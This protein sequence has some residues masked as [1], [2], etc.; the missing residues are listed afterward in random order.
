MSISITV[1]I[2]FFAILICASPGILT[3]E[4]GNLGVSRYGNPGHSIHSNSGQSSTK[5]LSGP[6]LNQG[7]KRKI[8]LSWS[9]T[10]LRDSLRNLSRQQKIAVFLDRR[11]D[12][13][14]LI[15]LQTDLLPIEEIFFIIAD[16]ADIAVCR[17]GNLFYFGPRAEV[18]GLRWIRQSH[19]ENAKKLPASSRRILFSPGS[20]SWTQL[21]QPH[22]VLINLTD[23]SEI[24][25][26]DVNV[27]HDLWPAYDLPPLILLD[28]LL[29]LT[30]GFNQYLKLSAEDDRIRVEST[31]QSSPPQRVRDQFK[32]DLTKAKFDRIASQYSASSKLANGRVELEG[33]P[34]EIYELRRKLLTARAQRLTKSSTKQ[35]HDKTRV[36]LKTNVPIQRLLDQVAAK[37]GVELEYSPDIAPILENRV[38]INV[39]KVTYSELIRKSL[40]GTGIQFELTENALVLS[41]N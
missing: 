30:Y 6:Q 28:R 9:A 20:I 36:S 16:K 24:T 17:M 7:L 41:R 31:N 8:S 2:C 4:A 39:T 33:Q 15:E 3:F 5:W 13:G 1:K 23:E 14:Q 37:M 40:E 32:C 26:G 29:V 34:L 19:I 25:L 35:L 21:S 10:P 38:E 22:D 12:P 18:A 11:V 27:E